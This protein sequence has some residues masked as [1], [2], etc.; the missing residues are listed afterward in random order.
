MGSKL[1]RS[2]IKHI[3]SALR[4]IAVSVF[5]GSMFSACQTTGHVGGSTGILLQLPEGSQ[6]YKAQMTLDKALEA[7]LTLR[8]Q[9]GWPM[10]YSSDLTKRWGEFNPC[11][12]WQITVQPPATPEV[13]RL[14][15]RAAKATGNRHYLRIAREAADILV[16]G[17]LAN[18]GW[19]HEIRLDS[20]GPAEYYY[21]TDKGNHQKADLFCTATLDD[22]V[23]QGTIEFLMEIGHETGYDA[24]HKSAKAG[25]D[26]LLSAQ[27]PI[28]GWPQEYP[29]G[30][31]GYH[32][33]LTLNDGA[34]TDAMLTLLKGYH[35]YQDKRYLDAAL[36]A[37]DWLIA[38]Q[39]PE[40]HR[41]WGAT[42]HI[43]R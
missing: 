31:D 35:Q 8:V 38:F 16:K 9:G 43:G 39:M 17:Q 19:W 32:R 37:A 10:A 12:E 26:F 20:R 25:L 2:A 5:I 34:S 40:P 14:Y 23:T 3:L 33:Y 22:K 13:G 42:I 11:D 4:L 36:R 30:E 24:Y 27:Y 18:G 7:F 28:G 6:A 29:P 41:G 15:L 21:L 1:N